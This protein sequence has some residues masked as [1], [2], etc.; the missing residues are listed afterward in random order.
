MTTLTTCGRSMNQRTKNTPTT[1]QEDVMKT[2]HAVLTGMILIAMTGLLQ[3]QTFYPVLK[4]S[5]AAYK[6]RLDKSYAISL[7]F[8][9]NGLVES[10]LAI[11]T[12]I[13]LDAP[14]DEFSRIKDEIDEL[15]VDGATPVI[16]FKAY[17]ADAVFANPA[18]FKEEASHRYD[19]PDALFSAIAGRLTKTLLS[20]N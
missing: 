13:K 10:A 16:R 19:D 15:T 9:N 6:T 12:M 2:K 7:S 20:S 4:N 8:D 5:T 14:S 18:M 11:V 17:L 1:I 3:A